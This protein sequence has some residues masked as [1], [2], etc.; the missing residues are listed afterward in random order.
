MK[1]KTKSGFECKVDE[2]RLKD[3]R[4]VSASARLAKNQDADE[5]TLID[6]MDYLITFLLGEDQRNKLI[7]HLAAAGGV[8]DSQTII[9]EFK[10]ITSKLGE[11]LKKSASSPA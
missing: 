3:W 6:G 8:C 2:N 7:D 10:E 5:I 11:Q 1:V 4:Y 9:S